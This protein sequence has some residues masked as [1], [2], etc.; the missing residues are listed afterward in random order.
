[1]WRTAPPRGK[2]GYGPFRA[3]GG[4][5]AELRQPLV[6][7]AVDRDKPS[8]SALKWALDNI[9]P[10]GQTVMLVHVASKFASPTV[11]SPPRS[12]SGTLS[13][14]LALSFSL[15]F[16]LSHTHLF[17]GRR[18]FAEDCGD[19]R[20]K[21]IFLPFRCF[22]AKKDVRCKDVLLDDNDVAK[23]ITEFLARS[24]VEK[25]VI[26]LPSRNSFVRR[27]NPTERDIPTAICRGAPDFCTVYVAVR[28]APIMCPLHPLDNLLDTKGHFK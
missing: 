12:L 1:M 20:A 18:R 4:T 16:S 9:V 14:S 17:N 28:P 19:L 21:D 15:S 2:R 10:R 6:A 8:Q 25:L 7:V 11:S 13:L 22:C 26:G 23:A 24:A 27:F 3:E 5:S